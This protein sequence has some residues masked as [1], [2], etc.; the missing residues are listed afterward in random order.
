MKQ[1]I[2][3]FIILTFASCTSSGSVVKTARGHFHEHYG[4]FD[5]NGIVAIS[6][7]K[8]HNCDPWDSTQI[9]IASVTNQ[10]R[11]NILLDEIE[12][13]NNPSPFKGCGWDRITIERKDTT[14]V[15]STNGKVVGKGYDGKFFYFEDTNFVQKYFK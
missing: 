15:L 12:F 11:I 1:F 6:Y 5:R 14:I 13:A 7:Y 4:K 2:Y 10:K 8:T 3:S 9:P